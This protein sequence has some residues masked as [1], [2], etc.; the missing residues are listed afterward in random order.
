MRYI[1][2]AIF[3][4]C[5]AVSFLA[6]SDNEIIIVDKYFPSIGGYQDVTLNIINTKVAGGIKGEVCY[7]DGA[8]GAVKGLYCHDGTDWQF[9]GTAG[10]GGGGDGHS[11]DAAD[12][13]PEDALYVDD[14]GLV[15]I[16][17][18]SPELQLDVDGGIVAQGTFGAGRDLTTAGAGQRFIWY[19]KKG[20]F[21]AG[22]VDG[23]QWDNARIGS[24]STALGRRPVASG[25]G[26]VGLGSRATG[27]YATA[28][29]ASNRA[30]ASADYS[31]AMGYYVNARANYATA[32]GGRYIDADG[33]YSTALGGGYITAANGIASTAAGCYCDADGDYSTAIGGAYNIAGGD[34]STAIGFCARAANTNSVIIG[35]GT[36]SVPSGPLRRNNNN[37]SSL[38][39]SGFGGFTVNTPTLFVDR[40]VAINR[41]GNVGVLISD[42]P[43]A[44]LDI[45]G[46]DCGSGSGWVGACRHEL[47]LRQKQTPATASEGNVGDIA[48]DND[49]L[50]IKTGSSQWKKIPLSP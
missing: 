24:Y 27:N 42:R 49:N 50:Y 37:Q 7:D 13:D 8:G 5:L 2:P 9:V 44:K 6:F 15:G 22:E 30:L 48:W 47:R 41:R 14:E 16:G 35:E 43:I 45:Y 28:V 21:R 1:V 39:I 17:T 31:T 4:L 19:P 38:V 46:G 20:A 18:T 10:G 32:L 34:Y 29:G 11:L 33:V 36:Y 23:N 40:S 26:A 12:G 25:I 3:L